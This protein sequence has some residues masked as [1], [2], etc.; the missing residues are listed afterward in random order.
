MA[1]LLGLCEPL[2]CLQACQHEARLH[3][4]PVSAG[5]AR[6]AKRWLSGQA[7]GATALLT[8]R[9]A[10]FAGPAQGAPTDAPTHI[11]HYD[12]VAVTGALAALVV[13]VAL[14][15]LTPAPLGAAPQRTHYPRLRPPIRA[16][17][18]LS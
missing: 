17:I 6:P 1:I 3:A 4:Q 10:C 11:L 7:P 15:S 9:F 8:Q 2:A 16:G 18:F 13:V 14:H 12:H 5:D